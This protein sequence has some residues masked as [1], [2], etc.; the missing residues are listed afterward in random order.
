MKWSKLLPENFYFYAGDSPDGT[1]V[2]ITPVSYFHEYECVYD[3]HL[4]IES[5]LPDCMSEEME[6]MFHSFKSAEETRQELLKRN[7]K[8]NEKF[9][10]FCKESFEEGDSFLEMANISDTN[11]L[12]APLTEEELKAVN[13]VD[14]EKAKPW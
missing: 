11:W 1:L 6:C 10:K 8:E 5:L 14:P 9:T 3:Q 7:F 12:S 13:E 2:I 4:E